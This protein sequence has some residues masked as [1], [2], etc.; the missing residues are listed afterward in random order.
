[1]RENEIKKLVKELNHYR[2]QYY[3]HAISEISDHDYDELFD[4]LQK[5]ESETGYILSNS[6]TQTVGYEVVSELQKVKHS[7]PMLSLSKTKSIEELDRFINGKPVIIS[8]KLD[9][10]TVLLTYEDGEL[11]QAET[12]GNGELGEL[13]TH[14]AKVFDNIPLH[15][16]RAGHFEVEGEAI[17]TY[18][19]FEDINA[20]LSDE[21]K[22]K[23]PRNL[24]AGSVRQ[25]D[26]SIAKERHLKFI[27]WKIPEDGER[28]T[29][30]E[31]LDYAEAL[32]FDVVPRLCVTHIENEHVINILKIQ[33][34]NLG[35][36]IDGMV[37]TYDDIK[38][39]ESLGMTGHHPKHSIAFKFYDETVETELLD[40]EWTMGKTGVLTPVAVFNP[41]EIE[42]TTVERANLHNISVMFGL[43]NYKPWYK[44]MRIFV[45]KANMIIPQVASVIYENS[46]NDNILDIPDVCPICRM[47]TGQF[48][49]N[50][51]TV[52]MCTNPNCKGK[53]LGVLKTFCSKQAHDIKGLS[54]A[55]LELLINNGYLNNLRDLFYL[56]NDRVELTRLPGLGV[57][58][59][60]GILQSIE[61]CRKTTLSKFICGLSIPL[62]GISTCKEI[63]K[64]ETSKANECGMQIWD[65]FWDDVVNRRYLSNYIDGFGRVMDESFH[66]YMDANI[67]FV[68]ELST[69]FI[70]DSV[71][72]NISA[73]DNSLNGKKICITGSLHHFTN[74]DELVRN[75]ESHGGK[76]VSSVS[77]KTDY[78]LT[79]DKESG[80][81]KNV[82][83]AQLDIPIIS[84]EEYLSL[85]GE[86]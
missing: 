7:H 70:F 16:D 59:V 81:G 71:S 78:L 46:N 34:N 14:N 9:G 38:Y 30:R 39:G 80:S 29:M 58:K 41:V 45:Y 79:N 84:E 55:T 35:Y 83:A 21:Q 24:A 76:V 42:G 63:E 26:S 11:V 4:R 66:T 82:K 49:E 68:R 25:L 74:R 69:E 33:A 19:D 15:I 51:S 44:G 5:L 77:S 86:V 43:S 37:V 3:N 23:N 10:L 62:F 60:D 75:I 65:A 1:M 8:C 48:T 2:D 22:Y 31:R 18:K 28:N 47:E 53:L 20:R 61:K 17:I 52:L 27:A 72:D 36:P 64:Y 56:K 13:I 67:S 32:G 57:K 54:E 85:C 40:I 6:P 73:C 12:R 50:R